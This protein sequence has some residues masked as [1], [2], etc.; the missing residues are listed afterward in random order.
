MLHAA[1][2]ACESVAETPADPL[3]LFLFVERYNFFVPS[4]VF[5]FETTLDVPC[6]RLHLRSAAEPPADP[7]PLYFC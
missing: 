6:F 5:C 1:A 3:L 2:N 4:R 7:R